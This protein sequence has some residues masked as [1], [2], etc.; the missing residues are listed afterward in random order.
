M[1]YAAHDYGN[2]RTIGK[3][4]IKIEN[5]GS[6]DNKPDD[7]SKPFTIYALANRN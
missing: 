1:V 6:S 5:S 3:Y 2:R 7:S 4:S